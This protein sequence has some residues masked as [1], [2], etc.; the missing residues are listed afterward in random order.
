MDNG[1]KVLIVIASCIVGAVINVTFDRAFGWET[2][3]LIGLGQG[4][5]LVS[6]W[7]GMLNLQRK[8]AP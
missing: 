3:G 5:L 6:L 1:W 8:T 4:W 7:P 2:R